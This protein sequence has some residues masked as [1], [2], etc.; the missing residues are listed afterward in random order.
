M[1]KADGSYLKG[2]NRIE[3]QDLLILDDF[4]LQPLD[5]QARMALLEII[6]DR[7]GSREST[8]IASQLPVENW[9]ETIGDRSVGDA[10]LDRIVHKAHRI[11]LSGQSLRKI[12]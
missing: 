3:K 5:A 2:L 9:H 7:H 10:I 4:G 8:I 6:E 11:Q 1:L 12:K